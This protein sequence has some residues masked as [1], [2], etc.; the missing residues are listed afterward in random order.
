MCICRSR[1]RNPGFEGICAITAVRMHACV[2]CE[3]GPLKCGIASRCLS[4]TEYWQIIRKLTTKLSKLPQYGVL[5]YWMDRCTSS[6]H[7][8][9]N[10][11]GYWSYFDFVAYL[12][13]RCSSF[14]INPWNSDGPCQS[15]ITFLFTSH[16]NE[17]KSCSGPRIRFRM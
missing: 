14:V 8:G 13:I 6:T 4:I 1:N 2:V 15:A 5:H 12:L 7:S 9:I 11:Y 10:K 16:L 3:Y 17:K